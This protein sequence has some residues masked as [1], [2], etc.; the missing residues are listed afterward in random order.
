MHC[1]LIFCCYRKTYLSFL[2]HAANNWPIIQWK[3]VQI[4]HN[5]NFLKCGTLTVP[6]ELFVCVSAC[7]AFVTR[8]LISNVVDQVFSSAV[9]FS[10]TAKCNFPRRCEEDAMRLCKA[11]VNNVWW[12]MIQTNLPLILRQQHTGDWGPDA[13]NLYNHLR[14]NNKEKQW[15]RQT[16]ECTATVNDIER[17]FHYF[18]SSILALN[19]FGMTR[20][21]LS[22]KSNW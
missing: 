9:K 5:V 22:I 14:F 21:T 19:L 16:C 18:V 17:L 2:N 7:R 6:D 8:D 10:H 4:L 13:I 3:E 1:G 11:A 15:R 12:C 20:Q